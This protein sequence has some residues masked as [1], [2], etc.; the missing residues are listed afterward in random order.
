[1]S[2]LA[3]AGVVQKEIGGINYSLKLLNTSSALATGEALAKLLAVP[4]GSAFDSGVLE[5]NIYDEDFGKNLAMSIVTAMGQTDVIKIIKTLLANLEAD[6]SI[7][8][9]ETYFI[10]KNKNKLP[11]LL[12]WSIDENG[13]SPQ[14]F[15]EGFLEQGVVDFSGILTK[16]QKTL[17]QEEK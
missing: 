7:V 9:F 13:L 17:P 10:G 5:D 15:M 1:M 3:Q 14:S 11:S 2:L 16:M 6:G 4:F 8:D 12:M